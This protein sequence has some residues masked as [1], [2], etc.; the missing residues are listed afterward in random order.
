[1]LQLPGWYA[2]SPARHLACI[3][4]TEY[5]N[6]NPVILMRTGLHE[7]HCQARESGALG[8]GCRLP[9]V[10]MTSMIAGP[11]AAARF[12]KP[13]VRACETAMMNRAKALL[14]FFLSGNQ[15]TRSGLMARKSPN[16]P[17]AFAMV[18][19]VRVAC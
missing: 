5:G 10:E 4:V 2:P 15:H 13:E 12:W 11:A 1:M 9:L 7:P 18:S 17:R 16:L 8:V 14:V 3:R 19:G 6:L